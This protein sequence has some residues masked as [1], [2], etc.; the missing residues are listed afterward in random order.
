MQILSRLTDA[1]FF[2][3]E[4]E[5]AQLLSLATSGQIR[6]IQPNLFRNAVA[7]KNP[8]SPTAHEAAIVLL[9]GAPRVGKTEILRKTFDRLFAQAGQTFPIYFAF[10][11]YHTEIEQFAKEYLARSIAAF[12]AFCHQRA[13][14]LSLT[15]EPLASIPEKALPDDQVWLKSLVDLFFQAKQANDRFAML[16]SALSAPSVIAAKTG[17]VPCVM[18]DNF[19]FVADA[20][21]REVATGDVNLRVEIFRALNAQDD[22]ANLTSAVSPTYLLCGL[23]RLITELL[24]ADEALFEKLHV[25]RIEPLPEDTIERMIGALAVKLGIEISDSTTE[26]MVQQL[27]SDLFYIRALLDGAAAQN[28]RLKSFMEFERIYTAEILRGRISYYLDAV[29][30]EIAPDAPARRAVIEGLVTAT[31]ADSVLPVDAVLERMRIFTADATTLLSQMHSRE[32]LHINYGSVSASADTALG[33]YI[34]A[35]YRIEVAGARRPVAGE[36]LLGEKLKHSYRLMMSRYHRSVESQLVDLLSSF[37]FQAIPESLFNEKLYESRYRGL[38]RAHIRQALDE[39]KERIRLPQ[40][41]LVN[42]VGNGAASSVNWRLFTASGFDGGIYSESNETLWMIALI[43]SKEP[44]DTELVM[45]IE[46]KLEAASRHSLFGQPATASRWY[47]SKAGFTTD[48]AEL[49]KALRAYH[50]N[51]TQLDALYEYLLKGTTQA[52]PAERSANAVELIIPIEDE[53]ELIAARTVEQ[54]ARAADFDKESINQIKTALIEACI[55]AAEHGD[56]PD[57]KIYHRFAIEEDRLV[58]TVSNKGKAFV[59]GA[60]EPRTVF[61][62][63][64]FV[65]RGRGLKI[66]RSLMDEV[67]FEPADDGTTLVMTKLLKRPQCE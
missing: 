42:D 24:P 1:E 60:D 12:I 6:P 29:L 46:Q 39:T 17:F 30:R 15:T 2:D 21:S 41:V 63:P 31:E 44:I 4:A 9:L 33:D 36:E 3:R 18:L 35:K 13:Q 38:S 43:N 52:A 45:Q 58:I 49:L 51:Y 59:G 27:N 53:A 32:L 62:G 54:I 25:L 22:F 56:S 14:L 61:A 28:S 37:D 50:S 26:L 16:R 48:A 19:H 7:E 66:I 8:P 34:R 47:I 55:N 57:R 23:Q 5:L 11:P 65:S 40:I 64:P 67:K 10:R 20:V